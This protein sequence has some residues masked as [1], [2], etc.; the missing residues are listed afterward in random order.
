[1]FWGKTIHP[2][3]KSDDVITGQH[4]DNHAHK[5]QIR[6]RTKLNSNDLDCVEQLKCPEKAKACKGK[7]EKGKLRCFHKQNKYVYRNSIL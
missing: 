5:V 1:M 4:R 7:N 6:E 2:L 3:S